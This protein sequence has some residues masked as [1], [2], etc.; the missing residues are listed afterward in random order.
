MG[1]VLACGPL[2]GGTGFACETHS[3][4][5]A[6]D[7]YTVDLTVNIADDAPCTVTNTATVSSINDALL[8]SASDPTTITGGS[9]DSVDGGG[10]SILPINLSGVVPLFNN[11]S[12]NNNL[13]SPG[14]TNTTNQNLGINAP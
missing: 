6:G 14:A 10:S 3:P 9:C 11:I 2:N 7:S 5:L 8:N 12:T 4:L 13:L 1:L